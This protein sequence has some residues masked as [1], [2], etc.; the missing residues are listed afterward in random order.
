MSVH[1]Q[2][3]A[4]SQDLP[5]RLLA[6]LNGSRMRRVLV[7]LVASMI[8]VMVTAGPATTSVQSQPS[9]S[10]QLQFVL[11][12][13][14]LHDLIPDIVGQP[15]ENQH[16]DPATGDQVQRTSNGL[17]VWRKADNWTA[18][19]DGTNN[20]INGPY[21]IA[22]RSNY[23]RFRWESGGAPASS[24]GTL[25]KISPDTL[26]GYAQYQFTD[27]AG[28]SI[29]LLLYVPP[30]IQPNQKIP[31]VLVLEGDVEEIQ[32]GMTPSQGLAQL[33]GHSYVT[34]WAPD[35]A[36]PIPTIQSRWPSIVAIPELQAPARFVDVP[37]DT[38]VYQLAP[39]PTIGLQMSKE[40]VDSLQQIYTNVDPDRLYV[41]GISMGAYGTWDAVERWPDYFAAAL[42]VSGGGDPEFAYELKNLPLWVFEGTG[43]L[44]SLV[45]A[46][47]TMVQAVEAAGGQPRYTQVP[48]TGHDI[49][50]SVYNVSEPDP[51]SNVFAWLFS[52]HRTGP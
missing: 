32:P 52:Q 51:S 37:G 35:P 16:L 46:S 15:L 48:S 23:A 41:T 3:T 8:F 2:A 11:G 25:T 45:A 29:Y 39:D 47:A 12:F 19:T 34:P 43:D 33:V 6:V 30:S 22:E 7:G 10:V 18:F 31:L 14:T 24:P 28:Q 42:P 5:A 27:S 38:G 44:P 1:S 49:W 50:A 17:L 20:W 4:H 21:G 40:L 36:N 26:G 9:V 13:R